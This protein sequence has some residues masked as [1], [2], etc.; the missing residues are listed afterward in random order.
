MSLKP[1]WGWVINDRIF[2]F[3]WTIPLINIVRHNH[4]HVIFAN[5]K[6]KKMLSEKAVTG[7][8]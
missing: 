6:M 5:Y 2:N 1:P 3:V 4:P 7:I 8:L